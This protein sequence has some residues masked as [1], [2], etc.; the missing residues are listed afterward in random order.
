MWDLEH[1]A[2]NAN[3]NILYRQELHRSN[4]GGGG[5][6]RRRSGDDTSGSSSSQK[7][8]EQ[9]YRQETPIIDIDVYAHDDDGDKSFR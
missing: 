3:L 5:V 1:G 9:R 8:A 4:G 2:T 6:Q 7:S